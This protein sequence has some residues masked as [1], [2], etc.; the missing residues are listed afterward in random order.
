MA[1]VLVKKAL[2]K[3]LGNSQYFKS[4]GEL[5]PVT[6]CQLLP[7]TVVK[8]R[9]NGKV[10][11]GYQP[12]DKNKLNKPDRGQFKGEEQGFKKLVEYA[13]EGA[14]P[15]AQIKLDVA[16]DQKVKATGTSK[17]KGYQGVM[18]RHNFAGM[19]EAHGAGPTHRHAGSTGNRTT[20]GRVFK[21][22]P[23]PG[24]M[25]AETVT[26]K[27]LGVVHLEG[28]L[29]FIKGAVPGPRGSILSIEVMA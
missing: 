20:P 16:V 3:K 25:G 29:V 17:G 5:V 19:F 27:N 24:H 26:V 12:V 22:M 21:G 2:V 7:G 6:I 14:E 18:K 11:V 1:E 23:M 4:S 9:D 28:D 13:I 15:G 10:W 8:A